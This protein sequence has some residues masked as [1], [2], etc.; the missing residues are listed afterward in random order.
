[1]QFLK[2]FLMLLIIFEKCKVKYF[3]SLYTYL[4]IILVDILT[5]LLVGFC[6]LLFEHEL[7]FYELALFHSRT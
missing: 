7:Q 3:S 6:S 1:M 2:K 5:I 4:I